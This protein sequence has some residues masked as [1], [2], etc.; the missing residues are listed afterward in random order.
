MGHDLG[1]FFGL[2]ASGI[3]SKLGIPASD[4]EQ[5]GFYSFD[6]K[7]LRAMNPNDPMYQKQITGTQQSFMPALMRS[8]LST[9][10]GVSGAAASGS[11]VGLGRGSRYMQGQQQERFQPYLSQLSST[12][13]GISSDIG[14][15][16]RLG[17]DFL[18]DLMGIYRGLDFEAP[19]GAPV[20]DPITG[21]PGGEVP[22]Y[23]DSP[24]ITPGMYENYL[25]ELLG[26]D[27]LSDNV[28]GDFEYTGGTM[29]SYNECL[30]SGGQWNASTQ[31]CDS[32]G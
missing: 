27:F 21:L 24:E 19:P 20:P 3:G 16:R 9:G 14:A 25:T 13:K 2:S 23:G 31:S 8:A 29:A 28:Y 17:G 11:G 7:T 1:S 5:A 30:A 22:M 4:A 10:S 6:P 12:M 18:S 15:A 32:A 26:E